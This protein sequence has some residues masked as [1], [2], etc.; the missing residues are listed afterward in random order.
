[1]KKKLIRNELILVNFERT[2]IPIKINPNRRNKIIEIA[3][4]IKNRFKI[5]FP[6]TS[7]TAN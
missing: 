4:D 3:S 6:I 1:M 5:P 7:L 2:I